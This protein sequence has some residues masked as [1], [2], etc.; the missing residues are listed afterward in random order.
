MAEEEKNK[1]EQ[2]TPF[3]RREA[4]RKGQVAKSLEFNSFMML[5]LGMVFIGFFGEHLIT[6]F[7][8][9][10]HSIFSGAHTVNF[11]INDLFRWFSLIFSS[12]LIAFSPFFIGI[13]LVAIIMNLL[14]TG[15]IFTFFPVK[16]DVQRLNPIKGFKRIFSLRMI[17]EAIKTTIKIVL[18]GVAAWLVLKS[19]LPEVLKL[20]NIDYR[21]YPV[22]I[23]N[24]AIFLGMV[25]LL[26]ML[27]V[28]MIDLVYTRWDFSKKMMMSRREVKDEHKRHEGDP[29]IKQRIKQ[30]QKEA[31][32]KSQSL[33]NVPNADVLI[34]NPT[35][36]VVAIRYDRVKAEAP[37]V[38]AKG[39]GE[40]ARSMKKLARRHGVP[41]VEN[42]S[43]A[44]KLF[45][46]VSVESYIPEKYFV[47]VASILAWVYSRQ[48]N[49]S[50]LMR[51]G[52]GR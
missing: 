6:Q 9:T 1:S 39:A 17:Y 28:A 46:K 45:R 21:S 31:A 29:E 48:G 33:Q 36:L 47:Q 3:K 37:E 32:Q 43:L 8:K 24:Q 35:H 19:M 23:L 34:T 27:V 50:G 38:I 41:I 51:S 22:Y 13:I 2:A 12:L 20:P 5:F 49:K 44:R 15:P 10:E 25:L 52:A 11:S 30:L 40:L 14:Q 7:L 26:I 18:F 16:P 4:K 42:K